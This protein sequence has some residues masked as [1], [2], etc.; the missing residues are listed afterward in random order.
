MQKLRSCC[1]SLGSYSQLDVDTPAGL[2]RD[3]T[4]YDIEFKGIFLMCK[5]GSKD[6]NLEDIVVI[7]VRGNDG[8]NQGESNGS[9]KCGQV[10][11]IF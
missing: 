2:S 8:L 1:K 9:E 10:H 4:C 11:G 6:I 7:Q 3:V 5:K